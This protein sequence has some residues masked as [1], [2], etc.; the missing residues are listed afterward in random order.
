MV[1]VKRA[2]R[3][4]DLAGELAEESVGLVPEAKFPNG[5]PIEKT[6]KTLAESQQ[7]NDLANVYLVMQYYVAVNGQISS[8]VEEVRREEAYLAHRQSIEISQINTLQHQALLNRGIE[9][10]LIY[11]KGGV[12]P[13]EIADLVYRVT[14]LGFLGWIGSGVN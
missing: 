2:T 12:K 4:A 13:E 8:R 6:L 1:L 5:T 10:L 9:G 7:A 3:L 11:H 14:Q